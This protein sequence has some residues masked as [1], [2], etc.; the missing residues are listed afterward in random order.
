[1]PE[2]GTNFVYDLFDW[3]G[4][5]R[6][7][8]KKAGSLE[9]G[10]S[11]FKARPVSDDE[12]RQQPMSRFKDWVAVVT[13]GGGGIGRETCRR[14]AREGARVISV[15]RSEG[16]AAQ[17]V[18]AVRQIG[19]S[20]AGLVLDV[21]D[22]AEVNSAFA[23]IAREYGRFD[24]L[25]N[26]AGVLALAPLIGH[27]MEVWDAMIRVN[28]TGVFVCGKAAAEHMAKARRGSIVN[29]S[30]ISAVRAVVGQTAYGA[31]KAGVITV[32]RIMASELAP[33]GVRVNAIL[34][35]QID[36]PMTADQSE[37]LRT[38][39]AALIPLGRYGKP[40]EVANAVCF[41]AS[42]EASFITGHD[43]PV[44]GGYL[45]FGFRP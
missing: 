24:V 43:L 19:L 8:S 45:A 32:T 10:V 41:L 40:H 12:Y 30:S 22:E 21:S 15:D 25:V 35:A 11:I 5:L 13:G 28:L 26:G 33:L 3:V 4:T 34:P 9:P 6:F 38:R 17:G 31:S 42:D 1:L 44:D 23:R 36:T 29:I 14:F 39:R 16:M 18:A 7:P 20:A 2:N 27:P 37:D